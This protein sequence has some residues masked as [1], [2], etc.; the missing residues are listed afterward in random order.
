M[1]IT[2]ISALPWMF[3]GGRI[4]A[5]EMTAGEGNIALHVEGASHRS[6]DYR[7]P[8]WTDSRVKDSDSSTDTGSI[9]LS[10]I[11]GLLH[12]IKA[13]AFRPL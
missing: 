12:P 6:R 1:A 9:G 11:G 2:T 10:S 4:G 5:V 7:V 3:E 13:E 8:N